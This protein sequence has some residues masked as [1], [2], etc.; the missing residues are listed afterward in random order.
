MY[1]FKSLKWIVD[2]QVSLLDEKKNDIHSEKVTNMQKLQW[3]VL[4]KKE[5]R[6]HTPQF[7]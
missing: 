5:S 4:Q 7:P 3:P 1:L 2:D 6:E